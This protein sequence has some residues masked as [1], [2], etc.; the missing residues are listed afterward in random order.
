LYL[1]GFLTFF[2]FLWGTG[3]GTFSTT[4]VVVVVGGSG[5][6]AGSCRC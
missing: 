3:W 2:G 1:C 5:K 6:S 4:V